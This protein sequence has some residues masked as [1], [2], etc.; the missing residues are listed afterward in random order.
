ML[1]ITFSGSNDDLIDVGGCEGGDEFC[2]A[3][4]NSLKL[5]GNLIAPDGSGM[6]VL[7]F[8]NQEGRNSSGCWSFALGQV[9]E[10]TP[11]P[12]WK[13]SIEQSDTFYSVI[14]RIEAPTGTKFVVDDQYKP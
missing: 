9:D 11:W 6:R 7:A 1:N 14:V 12:G 5:A 4:S 3:T 8:Y 10:E 13:Q 2:N